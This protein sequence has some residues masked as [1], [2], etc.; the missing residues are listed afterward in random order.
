MRSYRTLSEAKVMNSRTIHKSTAFLIGL[1]ALS[2]VTS[3]QEWRFYGGDAGGTRSFSSAQIT[4]QN[5]AQLK[6]S[7]VYHTGEMQRQ[8]HRT[9]RHR[10]PPF[11]ST[12]LMVGDILYFSTPSNRVVALDAESGREIWQF[13]PQASRSGPRQFHQHRGRNLLAERCWRRPP[14]S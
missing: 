9:T 8:Q 1:I 12:P 6:P 4:P 14:D 10:I 13:D 7:W 2:S 5:V 11:E 3:A